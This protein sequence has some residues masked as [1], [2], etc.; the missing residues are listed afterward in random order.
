[1]PASK[2]AK[3]RKVSQLDNSNGGVDAS[4]AVI[5]DPEG[6][7]VFSAQGWTF[8]V[9]SAVLGSASTPFR[10]MLSPR[11]LLGQRLDREDPPT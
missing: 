5:S 11:F 3:K 4:R 1:M 2:K 10:N 8:R 7:V 6:D 9:C